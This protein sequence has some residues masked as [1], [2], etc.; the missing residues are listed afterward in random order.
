MKIS[1]L[2]K[3]WVALF[4]IN[5]ID[6]GLQL[7]IFLHKLKV[8]NRSKFI[9]AK[10]LIIDRVTVWRE[11]EYRRKCRHSDQERKTYDH[12]PIRSIKPIKSR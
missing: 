10:D 2:Q 4:N 3:K 9:E 11:S 6:S 5:S 1:K 7:I 8:L 12:K